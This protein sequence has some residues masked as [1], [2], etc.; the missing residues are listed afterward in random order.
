MAFSSGGGRGPMADINVT[1]LVDVM[2]VLLI[3]FIVTA[4]IMTYPI[5]VDL[6][7]RVINPPPQLRDP[8]P[9][10]DLRIDASNQLFWNNSP[11]AVTA[12]PQMMENEVQRDPTNQ[13]ELRI[14]AN[15]D[16]EYEVMAKVLAAA[17]NSDMKKIGFVQQ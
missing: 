2:L 6:P 17:K 12:L 5:D 7:Q 3:I 14:D 10:I 13:P 15:P 8:P 11:V 4:P 1:P 16:S 9:P